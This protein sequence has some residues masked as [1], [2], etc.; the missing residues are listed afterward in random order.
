MAIPTAEE[1]P[2]RWRTGGLTRIMHIY[3]GPSSGLPSDSYKPS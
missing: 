3:A 2:Q 1:Q